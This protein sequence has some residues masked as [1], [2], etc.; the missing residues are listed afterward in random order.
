MP[1]SRGVRTQR[2][3]LRGTRA[4]RPQLT[5]SP[6]SLLNPEAQDLE[7]GVVLRPVPVLIGRSPHPRV[8]SRAH[9]CTCHQQ[10]QLLISVS[11]FHIRSSL[12]LQVVDS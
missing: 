9:C 3:T 1:G 12:H 5:P 6:G 8:H 2:G 10:I 7:Q 11:I 4:S